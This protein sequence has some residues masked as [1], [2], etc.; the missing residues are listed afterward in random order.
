MMS[1]IRPSPQ[2]KSRRSGP[3]PKHVPQRTCVVCRDTCAKRALT[4]IVRTGEGTIEVDPTGRMNGRGAYLCDKETCWNRAVSTPVLGNALKTT[5]T[6]E[7]LT[8]LKEF[9]AAEKNRI[10]DND[11]AAAPKE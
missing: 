3:R 8:R 9:A 7:S 6:H 1:Q 5:L 4:R 2:K 11:A 10:D